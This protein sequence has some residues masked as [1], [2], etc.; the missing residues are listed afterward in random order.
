MGKINGDIPAAASISDQI[1]L[2]SDSS[3]PNQ[4]S[5]KGPIKLIIAW[6]TAN[7]LPKVCVSHPNCNLL[8]NICWWNISYIK[9]LTWSGISLDTQTL[10][11]FWCNSVK[12]T[13][14]RSGC[15][16]VKEHTR[17]TVNCCLVYVFK[18]MVYYMFF[19]ECNTIANH[20]FAYV[21][22]VLLYNSKPHTCICG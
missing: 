20:I 7:V 10:F 18:S 5:A 9:Y 8:F 22:I 2:D 15:S 11:F 13:V 6:R 14:N 1:F 21:N 17:L 12:F 16:Q 3:L 19:K 4:N